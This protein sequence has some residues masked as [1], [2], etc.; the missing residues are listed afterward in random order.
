MIKKSLLILII[1]IFSLVFLWTDFSLAI[2]K[3][4]LKSPGW[5]ESGVSLAP[6]LDWD[7]V[8]GADHYE[9]YYRRM[10]DPFWTDKYPSVSEYTVTGLSPSTS[11]EWYV[12]SCADPDCATSASSFVWSF[13]TIDLLPPPENGNSNGNG[14][15]LPKL[16]NPLAAETLEEAI[17]A[18]LNFLV[19]L[20]MIVAPI[21][22]IYAG[23][24][25]LTAAGNASQINK[26]RTILFWTLAA[27]AIILLAK[28]LPSI[29][30]GAMG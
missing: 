16:L 28:A 8:S 9:L 30:K 2:A 19:Y 6:V 20:A 14:G 1:G 27:V 3:P 13:I 11:Y 23:F 26:A 15:P 18:L 21:M 7:D 29:I 17:D 12:V 4:T 5:G 25:I 24:L 10:V 22:I